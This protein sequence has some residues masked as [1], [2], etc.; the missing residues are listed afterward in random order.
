M[1][2]ATR[3]LLEAQLAVVDVLG[4]G[5]KSDAMWHV[6]HQFLSNRSKHVMI[7]GCRSKLV[8]VV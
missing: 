8:D 4:T 5:K 7:N 1:K 2:G 3:M 6:P